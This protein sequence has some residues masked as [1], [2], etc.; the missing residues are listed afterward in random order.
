MATSDK[1]KK[2]KFEYDPWKECRGKDVDA[3][4]W[5][6]GLV[7]VI[8]KIKFDLT[9]S[10]ALNERK[11]PEKKVL[12][13]AYYGGPKMAVIMFTQQIVQLKD[14]KKTADKDKP[15]ELKEM[16]KTLCADMEGAIEDWLEEVASGKADNAKAL[17]DGKAAMNDI[18]TVDFKGA[19][20][21]KQKACTDALKDVVKDGKVDERKAKDAKKILTEMQAEMGKTTTKAQDAIK[22]LVDT[23][24]KTEKDKDTAKAL[25]DFAATIRK[26]HA[27]DFET[28]LEGCS[29]FDS[30]LVDGIKA[31]EGK[32]DPD[33]IK[34][35]LDRFTSIKGLDTAEDCGKAAK[36]LVPQFKS[37]EKDLK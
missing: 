27:A 19:F 12:D 1:P 11:W 6:E 4:K 37:I 29:N 28:F 30:A 20:N 13:E 36:A 18:K 10:K 14:D 21:G 23:A 26:D 15:G 25:Q 9:P 33:K 5:A 31:L 34:D 8:K 32:G 3:K 16:Y 24:K 35:A 2:Y 7:N 17:K 22:F